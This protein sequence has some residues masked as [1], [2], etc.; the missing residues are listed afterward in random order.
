MNYYILTE[1]DVESKVYPFWIKWANPALTQVFDL[2]LIQ[3]NNFILFSGKGYPHF[4]DHMIPAAIEDVN[5]NPN[6][7]KL[8]IIS[9]SEESTYDEKFQEFTNFVNQYQS[10]VVTEIIIQHFCI[11]CWGL[12]NQVII[13][14]HPQN[15]QLIR[16]L[17]FHSVVNKDPE[18][19]T[20]YPPEDIER[21]EF[22]YKYLHKAINDRYS[23]LT[24]S[25]HNPMI[26]TQNGY[27]DQIFNRHNNSNHIQ[28]FKKFIE[29]FKA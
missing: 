17:Q 28:S 1:G 16:Y 22:A 21:V 27:I 25:K 2:S 26:L 14:R 10:R 3:N 23:S 12:S 4:K 8:I 5:A 13:R 29:V 18:L 11:E 15:P 24:Y 6:F 19:L 20:Y 9:D 7:D